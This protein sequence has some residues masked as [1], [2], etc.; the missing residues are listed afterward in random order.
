MLGHKSQRQRRW[1]IKFYNSATVN[2]NRKKK[3][4]SKEDGNIKIV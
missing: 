1:G 4:N 3:K 2:T